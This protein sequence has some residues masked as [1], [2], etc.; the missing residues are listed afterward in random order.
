M[1]QPHFKDPDVLMTV[2]SLENHLQQ[3]EWWNNFLEKVEQRVEVGE[4]KKLIII[5]TG[6]LQR[7]YFSLGVDSSLEVEAI[8]EK[9]QLLDKQWLEKQ[10][11]NLKRLK[12]P[13]E[14]LNWQDLLSL[15]ATQ[16]LPSF[17]TFFQQIKSDY[18]NNKNK[19]FKH[20]VDDHADRYITRKIKIYLKEQK[21][22]INRDDFFK[23]AIDYALEECAALVQLFRCGADCLVYPNG[24]PPPINHIW[25]KYFADFSLR[26]ENCKPTKTK[27]ISVIN[28]QSSFF[29][30]SQNNL[31]VE[32]AHWA[33]NKVPWAS[34]KS[35]QQFQFIQ[36]LDRL[37]CSVNP[38]HLEEESFQSLRRMSH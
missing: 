38:Q 35:E 5:T 33:L 29:P 8:E 28:R 20:L 30:V 9:A 22:E 26:Y 6:H 31:T 1:P 25:K 11:V 15:P 34:L 2:I 32:Y 7:H 13:V 16:G 14:I 21:Q 10:G 3:G 18:F 27:A 24:K 37:L 4:L 36:G 23:V 19:E 17:E 12:V